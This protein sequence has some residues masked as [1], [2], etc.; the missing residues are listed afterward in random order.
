M[1]TARNAGRGQRTSGGLV[2]QQRPVHCLNHHLV[3]RIDSDLMRQMPLRRREG[4][5]QHLGGTGTMQWQ[6]AREHVCL[7]DGN[8][9]NA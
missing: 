7:G 9:P 6:A 5:R 1:T 4:I 8:P 2:P 3:F